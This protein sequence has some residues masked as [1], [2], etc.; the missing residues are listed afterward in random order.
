MNLR[1]VKELIFLALA[2]VCGVCIFHFLRPQPGVWRA[3]AKLQGQEGVSYIVAAEH[4]DWVEGWAVNLFIVKSNT[5]IHAINLEI[6]TGPWSGVRLVESNHIVEIRRRDQVYALYSES[7]KILKN[8]AFNEF[9]TNTMPG[10]RLRPAS[11]SWGY[12]FEYD[13][14]LNSRIEPN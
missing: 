9:F 10:I 3:L 5:E 8:C 2:G 7:S 4:Y 14:N 6:E 12:V 11:N 13:N 1:Y